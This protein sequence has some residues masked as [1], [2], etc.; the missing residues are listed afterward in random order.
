MT[1]VICGMCDREIRHIDDGK[2][3]EGIMGTDSWEH[4]EIQ[5]CEQCKK[6]EEMGLEK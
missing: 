2:I 1:D 3:D 4:I 5:W 6:E